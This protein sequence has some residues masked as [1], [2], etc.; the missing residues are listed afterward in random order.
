M[1]GVRA[2]G[3]RPAGTYT[4][5][6]AFP[7]LPP[8]R[9]P[10]Q[11]RSAP[12]GTLRTRVLHRTVV[13]RRAPQLQRTRACA[14]ACVA[15][16]AAAACC[17]TAVTMALQPPAA[18]PD[19]E[20]V[21]PLSARSA[22]AALAA[23][24]ASGFARSRPRLSEDGGGDGPDDVE[25]AALEERPSRRSRTNLDGR[26]APR[27]SESSGGAGGGG[28]GGTPRS[29]R[30]RRASS[31]SAP[32]LDPRAAPVAMRISRSERAHAHAHGSGGGVPAPA[33]LP[34]CPPSPLS[35]AGAAAALA[36][37]APPP[38]QMMVD[39]THGGAPPPPALLPPAEMRPPMPQQARRSQ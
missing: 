10:R 12:R 6:R 16:T 8:A 13:P 5:G 31:P 33:P 25:P 30:A 39:I 4:R 7:A 26:S 29:P 17:R 24:A 27:R 21:P 15:A 23:T 32:C 36:A 19:M 28:A 9:T 35:A 3:G 2:R 34:P 22:A 1:W 11:A 20:P 37:A 38:V 14:C 18:V